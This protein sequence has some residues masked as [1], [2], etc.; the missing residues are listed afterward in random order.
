LDYD[1]PAGCPSADD[2][3]DRARLRLPDGR[4]DLPELSVAIAKRPT[5]YVAT[6]TIGDG[7]MRTLSA[8][9]CDE[10]VDAIAVIVAVRASEEREAELHEAAIAESE[11]AAPAMEPPPPPEVGS[12]PRG[13]DALVAPRAHRE[14]AETRR[15][16]HS[17][18][19]LDPSLGTGAV[20]LL[21]A[22]PGPAWGPA[23]VGGIGSGRGID[24]NVRLA[25]ERASAGTTELPPGAVWA[26]W[27]LARATGCIFAV[28]AGRLSAQP[29]GQL[30]GGLLE[31]EG[32][33]ETPLAPER[34]ERA[35]LAV[36]PAIR[37]GLLVL[38]LL[39]VVLDAALPVP[40]VRERLIFRMPRYDQP[41][42]ETWPVT[43]ALSLSLELRP[44]GTNRTLP[45]IA[46]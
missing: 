18:A 32:G 36:G 11:D 9:T 40:L 39:D 2:L 10:I 25:L 22:A 41:A 8:P 12:S 26:R 35:W 14:P 24:W 3:A 5:N 38:P 19:T 21:G 20:L 42:H 4:H 13:P 7:E 16:A 1:A 33:R 46:E 45:G 37:V 44:N 17:N 29:C 43:V 27:T 6:V 34:V 15:E 23:I 28:H 30:A 31:A